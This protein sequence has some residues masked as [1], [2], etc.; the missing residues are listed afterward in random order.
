MPRFP[1]VLFDLDGTLIDSIELIIDS[2]LHAFTVHRLPPL[3]R[4]VLIAGIGTPLRT[5]FRDMGGTPEEIELWIGT[6]REYNLTHHDQRVRPFPGA[7]EMVRQAHA[8]GCRLGLVTSKNRAGAER[9]LR[10]VGLE[11]VMQVVIGADQVER[12]KPHP[13][14]VE[15]ALE[16]LGAQPGEAVFIGDST[17]DIHSGRAA[18]VTTIGVT[19]GPFTHEQL[20]P[21][22]P[23]HVCGT[24][25]DVL[26]LL[27]V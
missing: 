23:H 4:E 18:G 6:Y 21:A 14:P 9:G 8:A 11:G 24:P 25:A 1:T 3:S 12:P 5:V 7:V 15:R 19:W 10:L 26:A 2:Y 16:A 22:S 20:L 27:E 13:E 17:H